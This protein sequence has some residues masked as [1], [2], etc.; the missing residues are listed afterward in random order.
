MVYAYHQNSDVDLKVAENELFLSLR[1]SYDLYYY[2]L[3][4]IVDVT[5]LQERRLETRKSKYRPSEEELSPNTRLVDNRFAQ[6]VQSNEMLRKYVRDHG[7][8]WVHEAG[9]VKQILDLILASDVYKT[10]LNNPN[11]SYETDREFWRSVFR[12]LLCGNEDLENALE[13]MSIYWND[14]V[15]IIETFIIKT[16][17][18]FEESAG[19]EQELLPMYKDDEHREFAI[20]LFRYALMH[21]AEYYERIGK[22]LKNWETE[23]IAHMDLIIMQVALAEIMYFPKIPVNVTLSEYI[24]AAKYYSTPRSGTFINGI[25]DAVVQDL[26]KEKILLK[27]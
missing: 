25:L 17:R 22:H 2:F 18:Q 4:L 14:D 5:R 9:F 19:S 23:R 3:L 11:D 26:R 27:D 12:L 15:D 20:K 6:Q 10:Y 8:S 16:I 1:R 21:R 13:D 7:I 24:D